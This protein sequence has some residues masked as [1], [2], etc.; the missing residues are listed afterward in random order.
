MNLILIGYRGV[1]KST[2]A[3]LLGV[4]LHRPVVSLDDCIVLRAR[5]PIPA[6]VATRGWDYFRDIESA[7]VRDYTAR[8]N[9]VLDCGGGVVLRPENIAALRASGYCVWLTAPI[10]TLAR[11]IAGDANRPSLTGKPP[12][13]E[14][15]EILAEREPLY[16]G[17]ANLIVDTDAVS[18]TAAADAISAAF[19]SRIA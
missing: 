11:R 19:L 1:G 6:L 18:A 3:S 5:Q 2:V 16:R 8:K 15:R 13:E 10:A 9:Q 12:E 7:V 17:L 14:I 4:R